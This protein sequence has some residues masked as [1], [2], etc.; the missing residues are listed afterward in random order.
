MA[1]R[2]N[3]RVARRIERASASVDVLGTIMQV[4]VPADHETG[5]PCLLRATIPPGVVI[6]LHSQPDPETF[7]MISGNAEGLSQTTEGFQWSPLAPGDVFHVPSGAKHALRNHW[8]EQAVMIAIATVRLGGFFLEVGKPVLPTLRPANPPTREAV[9]HFLE[10][11][12]RYGHWIAT[13]EENYQVGI[14]LPPTW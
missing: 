10:T 5:V 1:H 8:P 4:L 9:R 14:D 11:A 6:P 7:F 12:A 13:P 2:P 3:Q